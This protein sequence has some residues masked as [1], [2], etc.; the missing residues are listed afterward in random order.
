LKL[1]KWPSFS[2][3]PHKS[4][5]TPGVNETSESHFYQL[6]SLGTL[7]PFGWGGVE[8]LLS[9][10]AIVSLSSPQNIILI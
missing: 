4:K 3:I 5:I 10:P 7:Q 9:Y 6:E 2:S 1:P 8:V